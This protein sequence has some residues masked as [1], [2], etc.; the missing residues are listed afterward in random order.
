MTTTHQ[1]RMDDLK[2]KLSS[3]DNE[4]N[5]IQA[6]IDHASSELAQ[7]RADLAGTQQRIATGQYVDA[8]DL[9][10]YTR[11]VYEIERTLAD[12]EQ[13]AGT[14]LAKLDDRAAPLK[15]ELGKLDETIRREAFSAA[16]LAYQ[17]ALCEILPLADEL[18]RQC[19]R[20]RVQLPSYGDPS[21]LVMKGTHVLGGVVLEIR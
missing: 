5:E 1:A 12:L 21:L 4:R 10:D 11:A 6:N 19:A 2:S 18:I 15:R 16:V 8:N 3:I 13:Q 7:A 9:L 14:K 17:R 20:N